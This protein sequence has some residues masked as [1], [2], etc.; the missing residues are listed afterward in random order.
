MAAVLPPFHSFGFTATICLPLVAG[1]TVGYNANPLDAKA[2][3]PLVKRT[4]A[5]ILLGTPTFLQSWM[6][7]ADPLEMITLRHVIA[8]AERLRPELADAFEEKYGVRPLEGYG[9]TEMGPVVSVNALDVQDGTQEQIGRKDGTVGRPV[10][11]VAVR[12]VHPETGEILADGTEGHLLLKSPAMM[13][14]YLG[15][16]VRTG[17]VIDDGWYKTGDIALI[18]D[19]G[20]LKITDRLSRFSK[21]AG[22][23]VPHGRIESELVKFPGVDAGCVVALPDAARGEKIV[24]LYAGAAEPEEVLAAF[25]ATNLPK[26][27]LPKKDAVRKIGEVPLLGSGKLDLARAKEI[28]KAV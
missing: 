5:T 24:A 25:N 7:S 20:F 8:G 2:I 4:Q 3:G 13:D 26:L 23:M 6:R 22:E 11:G 16:P 21:I 12:I 9:M 27:W 19:D 15:D 10:P 28:A 17:E 1:I 18:D 14:G